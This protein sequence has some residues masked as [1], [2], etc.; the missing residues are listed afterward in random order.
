M[1]GERVQT[2]TV[3]IVNGDLFMFDVGDGIVQK[4]ENMGL[5]LN[6][7]DGIFITHWHSDHVIDLPS[8]HTNACKGD[9]LHT[10]KCT[11][12]HYQESVT[13][14]TLFHRCRFSLVKA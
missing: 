13:A 1:P 5:P 10:K 4:A 8:L 11:R 14:H 2:G 12:C 3:I 6:K 7:F 9:G